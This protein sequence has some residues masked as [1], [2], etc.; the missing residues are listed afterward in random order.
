VSFGGQAGRELDIVVLSMGISVTGERVKEKD[1]NVK[2]STD[3]GWTCWWRD[4]LGG[5]FKVG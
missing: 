1:D 4:Q 2:V 5:G 3:L